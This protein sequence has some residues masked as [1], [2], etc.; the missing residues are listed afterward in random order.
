MALMALYGVKIRTKTCS[1]E[2]K[3]AMNYCLNPWVDSNCLTWTIWATAEAIF[4]SKLKSPI[5][6]L[7]YDQGKISF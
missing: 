4:I 7:L 1:F 3:T 6:L 2:I 5:K